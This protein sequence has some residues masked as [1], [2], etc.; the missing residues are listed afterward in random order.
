MNFEKIAAEQEAKVHAERD[1]Q[2]K[3]LELQ[4]QSLI[5]A[6]TAKEEVVR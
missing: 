1:Q 3:L 6:H 2:Q 5:A 4:K